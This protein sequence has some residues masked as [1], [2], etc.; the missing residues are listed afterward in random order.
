M[1]TDAK[2]QISRVW[3]QS[4]LEFATVLIH[5]KDAVAS[6]TRHNNCMVFARVWHSSDS[7]VTVSDRLDFK[8][9]PTPGNFIECTI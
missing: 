7:N 4:N 3:P 2:C 1:E 6:K 8:H 9:S 5:F